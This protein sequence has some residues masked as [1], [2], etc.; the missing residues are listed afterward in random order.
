[1]SFK[2]NLIYF[3]KS[4]KLSQE[5]LAEQVGVSRQSV[6]KWETGEAYPETPNIL[7]LCKIFH[8]KVTELIDINAG[9]L[10]D[11]DSDTRK[12][13]VDLTKKDRKRL[14]TVSKIIYIVARIAR[15]ASLL[16]FVVIGVVSWALHYVALNWLF[17]DAPEGAT[18]NDLNFIN[19]FKFGAFPKALALALILGLFVTASVYIFKLL[20]EVERFFKQIYKDKSPFSIE[21]ILSLK[22]IAQFIVIWLISDN[23]A[24]VICAVIVPAVGLTFSPISVVYALIVVALVYIFRYGYLLQASRH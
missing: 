9:E 5:K 10:D 4:N 13:V 8:C 2:E 21:N 1:M 19:F 18:W 11:F 20:L 7:A 6:S 22:K 14:K 15:F 23:L 12:E 16:N 24:R 3:R 17:S